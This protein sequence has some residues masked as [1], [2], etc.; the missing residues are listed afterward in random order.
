MSAIHH[1]DVGLP[2]AAFLS[3]S[4]FASIVA[5]GIH[6]DYSMITIAKRIMK[7]RL[8]LVS[9]AVEESSQKAVQHVRRN[10]R[11]TLPDGT[12]SGS[13]LTMMK[14]VQNCVEHAG[15]EIEEALR[16]ASLYPA[17]L[18]GL[19]DRG[20]AEPG[21]KADLVVFDDRFLVRKV[22]LNGEVF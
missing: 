14:A 3:D 9:D 10:D 17:K 16:M 19:K 4:V 12:L 6:V 22:I 13:A 2:G 21:M 18:M 8:F 20:K 7:E 5:D 11:F 1:R 15:I